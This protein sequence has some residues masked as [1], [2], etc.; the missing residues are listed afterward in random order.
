[1]DPAGYHFDANGI[2]LVAEQL[3]RTCIV[4]KEFANSTPVPEV[5]NPMESD[6][7]KNGQGA[8][9]DPNTGYYVPDP[10]NTTT[11]SSDRRIKE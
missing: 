11:K 2:G 7:Y 6:D 1:M 9:L 10:T 4:I 8:K 3:A 5:G